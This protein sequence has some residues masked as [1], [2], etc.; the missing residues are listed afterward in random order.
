LCTKTKNVIICG[1]AIDELDKFFDN[2]FDLIV[3]DPPF[4]KNKNY[5]ELVD[6]NVSLE[7]YYL[8][9][10][11][12]IKLSFQKLK[13]DGSLYIYINSQHLGRFQVIC[14]KYGIWRNTIIW[15]YTNPTPSK[16][17]Y[18]KTWSAFLFFTKTKD[19]KFFVR[20]G[21]YS[22]QTCLEH[23]KNKVVRLYDCWPDISKLVSGY[24]AQ[25]ECI[26]Y[27][28]TKKRFFVFQLPFEL[29]RRV[30]LTSSEERDM[31]LDLFSH[32]GTTSRV[33]K[34]YGRNSIGIEI[35]PEYCVRAQKYLDKLHRWRIV[36]NLPKPR[37]KKIF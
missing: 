27:P 13:A 31:V 35:N 11:T 19:Y 16:K 22:H 24:L 26:F 12:W 18:P 4:N 2:S 5:G 28:G 23:R 21:M 25:E 3:A 20:E 6:D 1:K 37:D 7:D 34:E 29:I 36:N 8:W 9:T 15:H 30:V 32:S 14:E 17:S 33:C 10:E